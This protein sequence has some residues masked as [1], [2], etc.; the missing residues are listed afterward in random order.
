MRAR[1]GRTF[2]MV[3]STFGIMLGSRPG[4]HNGTDVRLGSRFG[5]STSRGRGTFTDGHGCGSALGEGSD[6][7]GRE[8]HSKNMTEGGD[9]E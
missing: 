4:S 7:T 9:H 3:C 1:R 6:R 2:G 8:K 5:L